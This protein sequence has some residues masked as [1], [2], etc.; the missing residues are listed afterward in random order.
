MDD[1]LIAPYCTR[2]VGGKRREFFRI[3]VPEELDNREQYAITALR[4]QCSVC[5]I[6]CQWTF[7]RWQDT[8]VAVVLRE[9]Y[10]S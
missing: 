1:E 7:L 6:P 8:D 10:A 9:S 5:R 4:D 2:T 3:Q